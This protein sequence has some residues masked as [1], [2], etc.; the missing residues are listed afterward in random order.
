MAVRIHPLPQRPGLLHA[1]DAVF[2]SIFSGCLLPSQLSSPKGTV[3]G[4]TSYSDQKKR[5][6]LAYQGSSKSVQQHEC[7]SYHYGVRVPKSCNARCIVLRTTPLPKR[8]R[9]LRVTDPTIVIFFSPFFH[10]K[11]L[12]KRNRVPGTDYTGEIVDNTTAPHMRQSNAPVVK[13]CS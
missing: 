1:V 11:H 4:P 7:S 10:P 3:F 2:V 13:W 6:V 8:S 12:Q 5:R 9:L